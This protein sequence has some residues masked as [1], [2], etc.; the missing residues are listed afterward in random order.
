MIPLRIFGTN[1]GPLYIHPVYICTKDAP[2]HMRSQ[3]DSGLSIPP[4]PIKL[5]FLSILCM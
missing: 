1:C 2:E 4:T 3:A 5:I